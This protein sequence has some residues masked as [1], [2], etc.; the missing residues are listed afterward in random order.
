MKA[1]FLKDENG[2]IWFFFASNIQIRT[3]KNRIS[4]AYNLKNSASQKANA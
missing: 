4:P 2:N 1:E 3:C